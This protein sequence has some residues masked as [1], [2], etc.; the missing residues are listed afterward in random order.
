MFPYEVENPDVD[1]WAM[2]YDMLLRIKVTKG[3]HKIQQWGGTER[4]W[5]DIETA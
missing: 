3:G 4:G 5:A 1:N 2:E